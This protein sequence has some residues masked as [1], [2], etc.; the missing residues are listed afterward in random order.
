MGLLLMKGAEEG[1]EGMTAA[2]PRPSLDLVLVVG[3]RRQ[4]DDVF[5]LQS[6]RPPLESYTV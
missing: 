2:A 5:H 6:G 3:S 1:G 4:A